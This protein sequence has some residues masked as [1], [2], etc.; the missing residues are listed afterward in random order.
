MYY[1]GRH[2]VSNYEKVSTLKVE[3]EPEPLN[4]KKVEMI[5]ESAVQSEKKIAALKTIGRYVKGYLERKRLIEENSNYNPYV[6]G[7]TYQIINE[8]I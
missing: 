2:K 3:Q 8:K 4:E 7:S 5:A 6:T 1:R